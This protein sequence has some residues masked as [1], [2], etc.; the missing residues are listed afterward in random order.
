MKKIDYAHSRY[1]FDSLILTGPYVHLILGDS[2]D[3]ISEAFNMTGDSLAEA[4]TQADTSS[5]SVSD[6]LYY[7][8]DAFVIEGGVMD[9]T[10]NLTGEPFNYHL[11]DIMLNAD[12][13]ASDTG[14]LNLYS[15]MLL[16]ERGILKAQVGFDPIDPM[17]NISLDYVINDFQLSDL[18]IYSRYYMGF[19]IILGDMYYK[20]ETKILEGQLNSENKLVMTNVELGDKGG[21]IYDVPIKL[22]LF[23]L[24]D[25]NGVINLDVPVRG[26]LNDPK[27]RFWKLL[28]TT[29]KNLM[30]KV[31]VAPYDALAGGV[32]ADPKE[33]ESIDFGYLD[34]AL[35]AQRQHQ[36]DLLLQL[37]EQKAGLAIELVYFNDVLKE[38]EQIAAS[39]IRLNQE[40]EI[41]ARAELLVQ[42]RIHV[43]ADYLQMKSDSTRIKISVSNPADPKNMG[44][45][46][47][48]RMIYSVQ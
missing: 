4:E 27:V 37:E 8:L 14:W 11:S 6:S 26:D 40:T 33:L 42:S 12:S 7:S 10:D 29:F 47:T 44:S 36:L 1:E 5:A 3:N 9:Y 39:D 35:T 19:P 31:A 21:G 17:H 28:W 41:R 38:M 46:P 16:N 48:F 15:Q 24:K 23:I 20:S 30:V 34:T 2:T 45:L 18:N 43:L 13:I 32:G 25:R 22:A